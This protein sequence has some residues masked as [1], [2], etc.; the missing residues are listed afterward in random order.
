MALHAHHDCQNDMILAAPK[1]LD[2]LDRKIRR[3]KKLTRLLLRDS[4]QLQLTS[5]SEALN[6]VDDALMC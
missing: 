4:A 5:Q 3:S 1:L 6:R 2:R